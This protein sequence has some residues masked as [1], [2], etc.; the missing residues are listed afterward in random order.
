MPRSAVATRQRILDAAY[1]EFRRRG[2]SR[3]GVDE[4]AAAA[5]VTKRTLYYHFESK[6]ALLATVL[7]RQHELAVMAWDGFES[8]LARDPKRLM[9]KMFDDLTTWSSKP[10]WPGSG[11]SRL[12]MELADLP[13]HP[14]RAVAKRHKGL[15]EAKL[16]ICLTDAGY[17]AANRL[18]RE[19]WLIAEGA[20]TCM[21]IHSDPAYLE[22]A[23][24]MTLRWLGTAR[25]NA[26]PRLGVK[27]T[28]PAAM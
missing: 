23:K 25:A 15:I 13:G 17:P 9:E 7:E 22:A 8:T 4:V 5:K 24:Q 1:R 16:A 18:A 26:P 6:D 20:M 3:V 11:F 10:R 14:A 12:A 28:R 2:Y 19:I 27:R 21:V